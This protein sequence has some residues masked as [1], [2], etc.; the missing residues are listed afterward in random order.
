MCWRVSLFVH[1]YKGV[2]KSFKHHPEGI[3]P[4]T[5]FHYVILKASL[6]SH[7]AK[8]HIS[9]TWNW[10]STDL[11]CRGHQ[12]PKISE[13]PWFSDSEDL[14]VLK[15]SPHRHRLES[16]ISPT[17]AWHYACHHCRSPQIAL[18]TTVPHLEWLHHCHQIAYPSVEFHKKKSL[19]VKSEE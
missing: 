2:S 13:S 17:D 4:G 6:H 15:T 18:K 11:R 9:L 3:K 8:S 10:L 7:C 19:G 12:I 5:L 16:H 14:R 1:S